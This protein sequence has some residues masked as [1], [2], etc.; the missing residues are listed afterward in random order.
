MFVQPT[1]YIP[2]DIAAGLLS[3]DFIRYGGVVRDTAGRL[4]IHLKEVPTPEKA[5]EEVA[6]RAAT[7]IKNPWVAIGA[8]ALI[9][10]AVG[11]GVVLAMKSRRKDTKP[12]VPECVK[13]YHQSLKTYLEAI[14]AR[15]LDA[16]II[17][18]LITDLDAVKAYVGESDTTV[19]FSTEQMETLTK[20]V[21]EYTAKLAE[22]NAIELD[23]PDQVAEG[24]EGN[25][26]VGL[27]RYLEVQK[28]IFDEAA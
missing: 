26:V 2:P 20:I 1:F 17:D 15:G 27:R 21:V 25:V 7:S 16:G 4:V 13:R 9:L 24:A 11:G 5:A 23:E 6:R 12:E 22:A 3:G 18:R 8:G 10:V 19:A 28:R 14:S